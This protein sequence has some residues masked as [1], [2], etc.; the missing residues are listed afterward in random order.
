MI[1]ATKSQFIKR[2]KELGIEISDNGFCL[3]IDAPRGKVFAS[4]GTHSEA[5]YFDDGWKRGEI[6]AELIHTMHDGI[7]DCDCELCKGNEILPGRQTTFT[8]EHDTTNRGSIQ[9]NSYTN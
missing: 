5:I 7:I 1:T 8:H 4:Y 6:Y 9:L 3:A 2:C